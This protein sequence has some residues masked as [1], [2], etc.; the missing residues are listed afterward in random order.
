LTFALVDRSKFTCPELKNEHA[1][2]LDQKPSISKVMF[3]GTLIGLQFY[4]DPYAGS[5][6][7]PGGPTT[8]MIAKYVVLTSSLNK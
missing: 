5:T 4:R 3:W 2:L 6:A 1:T 8:K 7:V